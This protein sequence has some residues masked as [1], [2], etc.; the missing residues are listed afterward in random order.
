[1]PR[2][3]DR[4]AR[5]RALQESWRDGAFHCYYTG[6]RLVDDPTRL[7]DHRYITFEHQTPG[8]EST[9]VVACS[10]VN[11]MK[12]DLSHAEFSVM[13]RALSEVFNGGEFDRS[14]FPEGKR[15]FA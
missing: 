12:T 7:R 3:A 14:A 9:I 4:K 6:M 10:L 2:R 11:R 1:M 8:D 13:V 5:I 15:P